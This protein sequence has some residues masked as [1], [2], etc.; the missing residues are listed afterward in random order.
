MKDKKVD[1]GDTYSMHNDKLLLT[2]F[3]DRKVV[4]LLSTV[5]KAVK[6]TSGKINP[7]TG[8]PVMRPEVVLNYDKY[9]G[10]VD[11]SD[12]LLTYSTFQAK[13]LK[14]WKRVTFHVISLTILNSYIVYKGVTA[15]RVPM[16]QSL[17][18]KKLIHEL[19]SS[20]NPQD[21]PGM[22]NRTRGRPSTAA[23]PIQR[24]QGRHF[25]CKIVG[26]G[27]KKNITR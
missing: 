7:A 6:K 10:G 22:G 1:K 20:V 27:K 14:W 21:V 25:P 15:D 17:F 13:T 26:T 4:H 3:H 12:Q 8:Q 2:K 9:M 19:I 24:L 23:G 11:R 16:L 18:R 5:D